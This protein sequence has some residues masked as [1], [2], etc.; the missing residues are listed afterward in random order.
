MGQI[1]AP[2][3][4]EIL[5]IGSGW[6]WE[7]ITLLWLFGVPGKYTLFYTNTTVCSILYKSY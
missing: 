3:A 4:I 5:D 2:M 6:D 1:V 7:K